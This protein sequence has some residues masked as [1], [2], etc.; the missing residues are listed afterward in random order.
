M[1]YDLIKDTA[2]LT[3]IPEKA[4]TKLASKAI[5]SINEAVVE[6]QLANDN[7]IDI[8]IGIG[9]L[10]IKIEDEEVVYKFVPSPELD[11]SIKETILNGRNLLED[12]L[13][14]SLV[15]KL[16]NTYKDIL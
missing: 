1:K 5:Y 16:T 8:D 6:S 13:E 11:N 12:A 9:N 2:T 14:A 15:D 3:T 4:L 7:V 10:A